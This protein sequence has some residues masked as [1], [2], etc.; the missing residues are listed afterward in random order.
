MTVLQSDA[1]GYKVK[2][3]VNGL[4]DETVQNEKGTFHSLS[5]GRV[6][7]LLTMGSPALPCI[8]QIIAIPPDATMSLPKVSIWKRTMFSI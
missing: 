6:E 5:L 8:N 2:V 1:L 3:T 4:Y 7:R